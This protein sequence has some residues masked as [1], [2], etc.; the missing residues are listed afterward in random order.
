[1]NEKLFLEIASAVISI[2]VALVTGLLIPYLKTK[3]NSDKLQEL[4]YFI[5]MAVRC[6]EQ[7][8]TP[9]QWKEKKEYVTNYVTDVINTTLKIKIT[10]E[11]LDALIE[12]AVNQIKHNEFG[13]DPYVAL[14]YYD[15]DNDTDEEDFDDD[16]DEESVTVEELDI[17]D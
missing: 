3:I 16:A 10:P 17:D 12:G 11:E 4:D 5:K 1:M 15:D 14:S 9:D 6:A 8:Y 7:L 13:D 2:A